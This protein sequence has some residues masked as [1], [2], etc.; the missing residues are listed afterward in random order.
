VNK[1]GADTLAAMNENKYAGGGFVRHYATAGPVLPLTK[2]ERRKYVQLNTKNAEKGKKLTAG[3][4]EELENLKSRSKI[5]AEEKAASLKFAVNPGKI[6]GFILTPPK[7]QD[8][9]YSFKGTSFQIQKNDQIY[10]QVLSN[11]GVK[12]GEPIDA[13][14]EANNFPEFYPG[15]SGADRSNL[16]RVAK[17]GQAIEKGVK[18]GLGASLNSL[19][20]SV[21]QQQLLDIPPAIDGDESLVASALNNMKADKGMNETMQGYLF[22][23]MITALTGAIAAGGF[24]SFDFPNITT[25]N[26]EKLLAL[27][28]DPRINEIDLAEAKRSRDAFTNS[29]SGV[30]SKTINNIKNNQLGTSITRKMATGG[31]VS[32]TVPAMLTPGEFVV[33]KK[34]AQ[35]I[36]Y[37][38]LNRMN[39]QGV[40]GYAKGGAVQHF[41]DGSSGNG[42]QNNGNTGINK[43]YA[44][45]ILFQGAVT[46]A[47]SVVEKFGKNADGSSN[48]IGRIGDSLLSMV[49]TINGVIFALQAFGVSLNAESIKS[50]GKF[51]TGGGI[52][53]NLQATVAGK[54]KGFGSTL[55][56]IGS[57]GVE[58]SGIKGIF[59]KSLVD[60]GTKY[61]YLSGQIGQAAGSFA[62]TA[63]AALGVGLAFKAVTSIIDSYYDHQGKLNKA[64]EEGD[65][66]QAKEQATLN[67]GQQSLNKLGYAAITVGAVF[68]GP[69]GAGIAAVAVSAAKL[70]NEWF[71]SLGNS[72]T[73]LA[74]FFGGDTL[75]SI[76]ANAAAS[77]LAGKYNKEL[78]DNSKSAA[79]KLKDV[80]SGL[81]SMKDALASGALTANL[82]N[83]QEAQ[84]AAQEASIANEENKSSKV[85]G[86]FGRGL[87][88]VVS[89]GYAESSEQRNL[90][91]DEENKK[92]NKEAS[93]RTK[94][95]LESL[96][97]QIEASS[98]EQ[99]LMSGGEI[100]FQDF[101]NTLPEEVRK[102]YEKQGINPLIKAYQIQQRAIQE[103]VTFLR[104]LNFG[105]R[106]VSA[107]AEATTLSL[108]RL[109]ASQETGYSKTAESVSVLEAAVT[110]TGS[111]MN[112]EDIRRAEENLAQTLSGF[113]ADQTQ[114]NKSVGSIRGLNTAQRLAQPALD[115]LRTAAI[116]SGTSPEAMKKAF[117]ESFSR[118][119]DQANLAP[120][121]RKQIEDSMSGLE[122]DETLQNQLSSG[123]VSGVME[124]IFGPL[125]EKI[126]KDVLDPQRQRAEQ[127]K[128]L[129]DLT[130]QRIALEKSAIEAKKQA[131]DIE[132]EASKAI[133][134]FGGPKVTGA[135]KLNALNRQ[136]NFD[137]GAARIGGIQGAGSPQ[138]LARIQQ[139][140]VQKRV[141]QE[142]ASIRGEFSGVQGVENDK[143]QQLDDAQ[144]EL[145]N[146][147]RKRL[148][149][150]KEEIETA[151]QKNELEKKSLEA[152]LSGDI[153]GFF[154]QA[155]A[156][157]AQ[158]AL[159]TGN[160][161]A[162]SNLSQEA[163]GSGFQQLK[164]FAS[165]SELASA[166][167]TA[168]LTNQQAG[169]ISDQTPE[170]QRLQAEGRQ[171]SQILSQAGLELANVK[172]MQVTA[173]QIVINQ[174]N[175][176]TPTGFAHGGV[177]YANRGVFVPR[178]T[179]TVPA[180]LTPG[181]FVVN[182]NAVNR[183][184]NLQM[185]KAMNS[186]G[187]SQPAAMSRGGSVGY[188]ADGGSISS[189]TSGL[190]EIGKYFDVFSSAVDRLLGFN[191]TVKLD[192][193]NVNVNLTG[194]MLSQLT[195]ETKS[196]VLSAV[197]ENIQVQHLGQN[198][199]TQNL[200]RKMGR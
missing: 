63:G 109:V 197:V 11:S 131:I 38:N 3:E 104:A 196:A 188:Y 24:A 42:V 62:K 193:V 41:A 192:P 47:S 93:D 91:I 134:E 154:K 142:N 50:I 69:L 76:Q 183:G 5:K 150:I 8:S 73:H 72:V 81:I 130:K 108:Q 85:L 95:E 168:G 107:N 58:S 127:E 36:G 113:G 101:F 7:G 92:R 64:I 166:A 79:E 94:Q 21:K 14:L 180:M 39:K 152:L 114:V 138:D 184:N 118:Q 13:F 31:S 163:I 88:K 140:I 181:E 117:V 22:E 49:T 66:A 30:V 119:L 70:A 54:V 115:E 23:G 26:K 37:G 167:R 87:L 105:L 12:K 178:G 160:R 25:G 170:I 74:S 121:I 97:P 173:Q 20:D 16:E 132:L 102:E 18:D 75:N 128:I 147:T 77:A 120:D 158:Q 100:S 99:L 86:R 60:A 161:A 141:A 51:L 61:K 6:G 199:P 89:L 71:P 111:A 172:Q 27:F 46:A 10:S 129:V 32:D 200:E 43:A 33:N 67:A 125:A 145:I 143:R 2:A 156:S 191:F 98:K 144:T 9:T 175:A 177:V 65:V 52:S 103:N 159:Q 176:R 55:Q 135:Q 189:A 15:I 96:R 174:A 116:R 4:K 17:Y 157:L 162:L 53:K 155:E 56:S 45:I 44:S 122:I 57:R 149:L 139:K 146:Y 169:I 186:G 179:D 48:A 136:F 148:D 84:K 123:N 106:D 34:A 1:I 198:R 187:V 185:L 28:G 153:E 35:S 90:R 190:G 82:E 151:K 126:K 137:L 40:V 19:I 29:D 194:S 112:P 59:S 182:R 78:A 68:G 171:F 124:K 195:E 164:Q 83:A 133:E 165:P 80:E 110:A